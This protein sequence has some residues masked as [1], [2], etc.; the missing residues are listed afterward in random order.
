[1]KVA[2]F[3]NEKYVKVDTTEVDRLKNK[4]KIQEQ[5]VE[6]LQST[7]K[8]IQEERSKLKDD[9][10]EKELKHDRTLKRIE[11]ANKAAKEYLQKEINRLQLRF[12]RMEIEENKK[13]YDKTEVVKKKNADEDSDKKTNDHGNQVGAVAN[14][15]PSVEVSK[16]DEICRSDKSEEATSVS[17]P[18]EF[19]DG[20]G[21]TRENEESKA[22]DSKSKLES[23]E[24]S[25][26]DI[27]N[28]SDGSSMSEVYSK[29]RKRKTVKTG[30]LF[31]KSKKSSFSSTNS[32]D[33]L[34]AEEKLDEELLDDTFN[35]LLPV[36]N[37]K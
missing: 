13:G 21:D 9:L 35:N 1:M 23:G 3:E 37:K 27:S 2:E 25:K 22:G 18:Q 10:K 32:E 8:R 4:L 17:K 16:D 14:K 28:C 20:N 6:S 5:E 19:G 33:I 26:G 34:S 29:K 11:A 36:S 30:L 12:Q 7:L 24:T 31:K 15:K